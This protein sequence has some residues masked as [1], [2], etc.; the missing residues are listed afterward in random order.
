M[1]CAAEADPRVRIAQAK[2]ALAAIPN[3]GSGASRAHTALRAL[4]AHALVDAGD[5]AS[6]RREWLAMAAK[7]LAP[8]RARIEAGLLAEAQKK[9][10]VAEK[11]Y[12]AATK[13][14]SDPQERAEAIAVLSRFYVRSGD[15]KRALEILRNAARRATHP[16]LRVAEAYVRARMTKNPA[17]LLMHQRFLEREQKKVPLYGYFL[18]FLYLWDGR[19]LEALK[20]LRGFVSRGVDQA[21]GWGRELAP[22]LDH[23]R[24]TILQIEAVARVP[25]P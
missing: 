4:L 20:T 11:D 8:V 9:L 2:R 6:A 5:L 22:E 19:A 1:A 25:M 3:S 17:P 12:Q 10:D 7:N 21:S 24:R 23:A 14:A 16:L 15:P 13:R 18:G